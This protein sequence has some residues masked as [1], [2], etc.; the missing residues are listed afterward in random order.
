MGDVDDGSARPPH[1]SSSSLATILPTVEA[2]SSA[3]AAS[4]TYDRS[5]DES[6]GDAEDF[7][8][9]G[10]YCSRMISDDADQADQVSVGVFFKDH[11]FRVQVER[12]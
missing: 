5:S 10:E 8:N 7:R 12:F 9:D 2:A 6:E 3:A 4:L 1:S 11:I